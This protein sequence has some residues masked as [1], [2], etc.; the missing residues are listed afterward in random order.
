[1]HPTEHY[2]SYD[3][4]WVK[5]GATLT[6]SAVDP[7]RRVVDAHGGDCESYGRD[8]RLYDA[9]RATNLRMCLNLFKQNYTEICRPAVPTTGPLC[10]FATAPYLLIDNSLSTTSVKIMDF[11]ESCLPLSSDSSA[12]IE[13][14]SAPYSFHIFAPGTVTAYAYVKLPRNTQIIL[15]DDWTLPK[16]FNKILALKHLRLHNTNRYTLLM[17]PCAGKSTV[18]VTSSMGS[19][20]MKII[21]VGGMRENHVQ[22]LVLVLNVLLSCFDPDSDP[23]LVGNLVPVAG[24]PQ[25]SG[26]RMGS[27]S[28][29]PEIV[30]DLPGWFN[31]C[32]VTSRGSVT[33][34]EI[35]QGLIK[36]FGKD[37]D[38]SSLGRMRE[39]VASIWSQVFGN[40]IDYGA[41]DF[42]AEFLEPH[43]A[44]NKMRISLEVFMEEDGVGMTL[45]EYF[46]PIYQSLD[47]LFSMIK[48]A[49]TVTERV[50]E[51]GRIIL[52]LPSGCAITRQHIL[53][54]LLG[55]H[56]D[57][58]DTELILQ[59]MHPS[60]TG[61][62]N[63][64]LSA[65]SAPPQF[66]PLPATRSDIEP[67]VNF[68]WPSPAEYSTFNHPAVRV[69]ALASRDIY[70]CASGTCDGSEDIPHE[71]PAYEKIQW[72]HLSSGKF[73]ILMYIILH[74]SINR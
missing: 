30:S 47:H 35:V 15:P 16:D 13:D 19:Q 10:H 9:K 17:D 57:V 2:Y 6:V 65:P 52:A 40:A 53:D 54:I 31:F 39:S 48:S 11:L 61:V 25:T 28:Q 4:W 69:C 72:Q 26:E 24:Q 5:T 22:R 71:I 29:P 3:L 44:I 60:L 14:I 32:D 63:M 55:Q 37:L 62:L 27:F 49:A 12:S 51:G 45:K 66:L 43:E 21:P 73:D 74:S 70:Y 59:Q 1:M 58:K 34:E 38:E 23:Y 41:S 67:S 33:Q 64:E 36:S 56:G 42:P 20:Y 68:A 46:V 50:D 18:I 8:K 7:L